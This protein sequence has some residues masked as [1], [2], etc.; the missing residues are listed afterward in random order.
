M[1]ISSSLLITS[2][3]YLLVLKFNWPLEIPLNAY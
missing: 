1:C 2:V 3:L